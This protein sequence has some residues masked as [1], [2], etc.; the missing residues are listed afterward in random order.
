MV[1]FNRRTTTNFAADVLLYA[2]RFVELLIDLQ[3][4]LPTRKYTNALIIDLNVLVVIYISSLYRAPRNQLFRDLV[5][6]LDHYLYFAVNSYTS[7]PR[8]DDEMHKAHCK[9][10]AF[11]QRIAMRDFK[12]K[13]TVLALSN[14]AAIDTRDELLELLVGLT[15]AELVSLCQKLHLR[16]SYPQG[17]KISVDRE[18]LLEVLVETFQRRESFIEKARNLTVYPNEVPQ[19]LPISLLS[20]TYTSEIP[21]RP[22]HP[23]I[24]RTSPTPTHPAPQNKSAIPHDSRFSLPLIP[25]LPL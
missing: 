22:S 17:T 15:D 12:E 20:W 24:S 18:F 23:R 3:S 19:P 2:E 5:A 13:L 16:T 14:F 9:E 8:S 11:L 21:I 6:E 1:C 4:Q 10:L 25:P 7:S